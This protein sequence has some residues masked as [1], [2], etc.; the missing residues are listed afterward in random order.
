MGSY[1]HDVVVVIEM[2][3]YIHGL[4][5]LCGCLFSQFYGTRLIQHGIASI[6]IFWAVI[7]ISI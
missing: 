5:I 4:L 2:G 3:A 7:L 1:K 6:K